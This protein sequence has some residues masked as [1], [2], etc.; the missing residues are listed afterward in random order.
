MHPLRILLLE[1][2]PTDAELIREI[3][4]ADQIVCDVK[5]VK[6][7]VEFLTKLETQE[8]D[9]VLADYKLPSFDGLSALKLSLSIRPD[10]PFIFVS[11]TFGE[12]SA[13]EALKIGA[14]DYVLKT[15][16]S[17]LVPAVRRALREREELQHAEDAL[18]RS[19]RELRDVIE[20][21]PTAAWTARPDGH[22]E[23]VNHQWRQYSGLSAAES[24][25]SGWQAAVH[26]D[27]LGGHADRWLAS[28]STG[29]PFEGEVRY[30]RAADG[31]YRWFMVRAV[32][33]RDDQGKIL[34][35]YGIST[36]V[37]DRKRAEETLQEQAHLLDLTH[38]AIFVWD[39]KTVVRYWNRG[40]EALYGWT[41]EQA[42]GRP[43]A[44]FLKTIFPVPFERIKEELLSAGRWEG[45]LVRT[46]RDGTQVSVAARWSLERDAR[47]EP[48]AVLE[49]NND[50]TESKKAEVEVR[51]NEQRYRYLFQ[52]S[53]VALFQIDTRALMRLFENV[54]SR[55]ITDYEAFL[56]E[57]PDFQ[58]QA[59]K[60]HI[61]VDAN[62]SAVEMF[63]AR[64]VTELL[65]STERIWG[66]N[67]ESYKRALLSRFRGEVIYQDEVKVQ[68]LDGHLIHALVTVGRPDAVTNIGQNFIALVD[69]TERVRAR[70]ELQL[71]EQRYRHLFEYSPVALAQVQAGRR[72][73]LFKEIHNKGV[74]NLRAYLEQHP[75]MLDQIM[76]ASVIQNVNRRMVEMFGARNASELLGTTRR[77]WRRSP[78]AFLRGIES[79]F[80]GEEIFQ[81]EMEVE[82]FDGRV[83]NVVVTVARPEAVGALGTN[84]IGFVDITDAVRA[85]EELQLNEQRYRYLFENAPVALLQI[86]ARP[87]NKLL[88]DLRDRGITEEK[89]SGYLKEHPD[90]FRQ[91]M[92]SNIIEKANRKTIEMFGAKSEAELLG[93]TARLF[94]RSPGTVMRGVESRYRREPT[95]EEETELTTL[96]GRSINALVTVARPGN[97]DMSYIS[98]MDITDRVRAQEELRLNEQLYR[99][100]FEYA[101]VALLQIDARPRMKLLAELR[102]QGVTENEFSDYL[103]EHPEVFEKITKSH[104]IEKANLKAIEMFGAKDEADL[105]GPTGRLF[106]SSPGLVIR[107]AESRFRKEKTFQEETDVNSLDGRVI[108]ALVTIARPGNSELSFIG[109]VDITDR[110]RA[111]EELQRVQA[112]FAHAARVATLGELAASIAHEINQ[113]LSGIITNAST[114]LRMLAADPPNVEGARETVRRTIRDGNRA[115]DVITR[116]R[117]M[118]SKKALTSEPVDLNEAT[119]E[120][121]TLMINELSRNKVSVRSEISGSPLLVA[122]DRTQLQQV[123]L[124]LVRN[125]SDA[126]SDV[127][128]RPR[129]LLIKTIVEAQNNVRVTVKDAGIGVDPQ[130]LE[131]LFDAFYTTKSDGMGVGLSVCRS[132]IEGHGGKI[133]AELN[134]GPGVTLSFSLP[135]LVG[136]KANDSIAAPSG[137]RP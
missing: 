83:I 130:N 48:V 133:W 95:F 16:L 30:R 3:L 80:R 34:K 75:D 69:I 52:Y 67:P 35:W 62:Q 12:D 72:A 26:P 98:F 6:T 125:A 92:E 82:T 7:R 102:E 87:R 27:D 77:I 22:V 137:I 109:F 61:I 28:L 49:T 57:N 41:A 32:P 117:A 42:V 114:G 55:D 56:N 88:R 65:G 63:G 68:A 59:V 112:E 44:E 97:H 23:F 84:F 36:D 106:Q 126:M 107:G 17:K 60:A 127:D 15:R 108:R 29:M 18:R 100:L 132:I 5:V 2:N 25:G 50:I 136:S 47:A 128:D 11:G 51:R 93:P 70:E 116:L 73:A 119:R 120:V 33:M 79:R 123:V 111:T 40:A 131:R 45:E 10:L 115:A 71:N 20:T 122:G 81:E 64:D 134:D 58:R 78:E 24:A 91:F 21:I 14:T 124:N 105:L 38:D 1:D 86:D 110:V 37:D 121:L 19:E 135:R 101:P 96:D 31:Q 8:I 74:T 9:L 94:R 43:V 118:F 99:Y 85:R 103:R 66:P 89:I 4:E 39:M 113:P 53:P 90:V 54:R 13:I 46:K 104:I 76:D 129:H